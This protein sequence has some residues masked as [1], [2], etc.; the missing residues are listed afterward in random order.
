[1]SF[2]VKKINQ[3]HEILSNTIGTRPEEDHS[4]E[5]AQVLTPAV[6]GFFV[7]GSVL[8]VASYW[9]FNYKVLNT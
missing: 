7:L 2:L 6:I 8:E 9:V 1:M 4:Y 3:R 5:R